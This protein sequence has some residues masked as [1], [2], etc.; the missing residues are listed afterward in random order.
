M[1]ICVHSSRSQ[2]MRLQGSVSN[3][4]HRTKQERPLGTTRWKREACCGYSAI[5]RESVNQSPSRRD[6]DS[7]SAVSVVQPTQ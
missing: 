7:Q 4:A 2:P 5:N 3:S 6:R 1:L